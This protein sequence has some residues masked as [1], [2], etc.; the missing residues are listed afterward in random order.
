MLLASNLEHFAPKLPEV[1]GARLKEMSVLC[2]PTAAYAQ[3]NRD[4]LEPQ[5]APLRDQAG[6]Y[7]EIDLA[8]LSEHDLEQA[9][10]GW[11]IIYVTGGNTYYLLEQAVRTGFA[12]SLAGHFARGG[13]Y[14]GVSAGSVLTCPS[15]E[16]IKD[17]DDPDK[18]SLDNYTGLNLV[19]C[20]ILPNIDDA[21]DGP[22]ALKCVEEFSELQKGT[23]I[24]LREDQGLWVDGCTV[25]IY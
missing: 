6:D 4:W 21:Q 8:E 9:M 13:V 12:Q 20:Y 11:D 24:G 1:F 14:V 19:D 3:D 22:E 2:I 5:I 25:R 17:M 15:I 23:I 10:K 7:R 16:Y 18:A